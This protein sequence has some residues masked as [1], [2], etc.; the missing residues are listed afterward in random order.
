MKDRARILAAIPCYNEAKSIQNV[1]SRTRKYVG[2]V[3]VVDDGST[4]E[5]ATLAQKAGATVIRHDQNRGKGMAMN[6]AFAKAQE[7]GAAALV[8]LDGDGQHDPDELPRVL[9]PVLSGEADVVIGSRFLNG[10]RGIP[11]YR[12]IGQR[13]L[14]LVANLSTGM[15][16]TDTQ[17]GFRAFSAKAIAALR[18]QE[19]Q[20]GSVESET[21]FLIGRKGLKAMEVPI[22]AIYRE[23]AK[24]NPVIQGFSTLWLTVQ[25]AFRYRPSILL[26]LLGLALFS[27][28]TVGA[29]I[30]IVGGLAGDALVGHWSG[31]AALSAIVA[32]LLVASAAFAVNHFSRSR[33]GSS[34]S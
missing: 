30:I 34:E 2:L 20:L 9:S 29:V 13:I 5:T 28:G 24:R 23:K 31:A 4:D 6:T 3:L 17:S 27:L 12:T 21:Q 11:F 7:L 19:R 1:V 25:L 8:L 33:K 32:G 22:T 26:T 15:K 14:T 16:M 10:G 18:F